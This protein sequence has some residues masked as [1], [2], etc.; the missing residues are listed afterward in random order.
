MKRKIFEIFENEMIMTTLLIVK[1]NEFYNFQL[2]LKTSYCVNY[3]IDTG[4]QALKTN[5]L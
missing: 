5:F 1:C 3:K 2:L 4:L